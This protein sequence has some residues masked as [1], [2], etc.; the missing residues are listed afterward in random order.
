[1][2]IRRGGSGAPFTKIAKIQPFFK[3]GE[4]KIKMN[5]KWTCVP[6][7]C[8]FYFVLDNLYFTF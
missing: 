6:A 3:V 7:I 4:R 5:K 2:N 8:N 1:M